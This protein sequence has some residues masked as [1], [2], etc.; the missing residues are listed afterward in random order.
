MKRETHE[1][2]IIGAGPAG[3]AAAIELKRLGVNDVVVLERDDAAGGMPQYCHHAG[4]GL[5]DL[6]MLYTGPGYARAYAR[7]A[8]ASGL[9]VRTRTSVTGWTG[10]TTLAVTSPQG[11]AQIDAKAILLATGCRERPRAARMIP[12]TRAQGV[13]TTGSLQQLVHVHHQRVGK[14]AV[15]VGAE[16]VSFSALLTLGTSGTAVARMVTDQPRHQ[17]YWPYAPAKLAL[18]DVWMR[19]PIQTS[20]HVTR[21]LGNGRVEGVEITGPDG[22]IETVD[23]DTVVFTCDW[24]PQNELARA[25]GLVID[26]G[27]RGPRVDA[28]LRTSARGVFAAGNLLRGA[29]SADAAGLEGRFVAS[30]IHEYLQRGGWPDAVVPIEVAEPLQW[31]APNAVAAGA[32][33]QPGQFL[34][35][36]AKGPLKSVT[37][38]VQQGERVLYTHTYSALRPNTS[39]RLDGAWLSA[40]EAGGAPVKL[41]AIV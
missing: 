21:I 29:E 34:R 20:A 8:A 2:A 17:L 32:K 35:L 26:A 5:R 10:P 19:T 38:R 41:T 3:L 40:V 4:F 14:K 28:L 27:T 11:L 18:A 6:H 15:I 31:V 33:A 36:R 23:C 30:A 39:E 7:R 9:P 24:I 12:G 16:L 1:V 13:F 22:A 25:G 37:V